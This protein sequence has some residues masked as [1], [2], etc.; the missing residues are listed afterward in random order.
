[1]LV[2]MPIDLP[3]KGEEEKEQKSNCHE[4][5]R[6][7]P[8]EMRKQEGP[9]WLFQVPPESIDSHNGTH[10]NARSNLLVMALVQM[11]GS[12]TSLAEECGRFRAR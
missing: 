1:M 6:L 12:I 11:S 3:Q 2:S 7:E 9:F 8:A 4:R 10:E 5:Y